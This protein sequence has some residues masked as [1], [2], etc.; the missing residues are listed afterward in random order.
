MIFYPNLEHCIHDN[1]GEITGIIFQ[2]N[3]VLNGI[4]D[5]SNSSRIQKLMLF[6]N[7]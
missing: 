6:M 1:G 7:V 3:L 2:H 5:I 4:K